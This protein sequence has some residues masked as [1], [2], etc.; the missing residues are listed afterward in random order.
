MMIQAATGG[1]IAAIPMAADPEAQIE[2]TCGDSL[3]NQNL[4]SFDTNSLF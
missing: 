1:V 3:P 2:Q 4:C